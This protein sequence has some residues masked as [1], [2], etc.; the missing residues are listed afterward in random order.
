MTLYQI[1]TSY[2]CAGVE[3]N[4]ARFVVR[5]A[6]ILAWAVG[7]PFYQLQNWCL[8]KQGRVVKVE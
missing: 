8:R 5:A 3:V 6:P 7:K 1:T 4:S 2:F